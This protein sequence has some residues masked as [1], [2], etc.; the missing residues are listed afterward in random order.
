MAPGMQ[1]SDEVRIVDIQDLVDI[2]ADDINNSVAT[3]NWINM[4][5]YDRI[6]FVVEVGPTWNA[7]DQLDD[8]HVNQASTAA[9]A[10]T[11]ALVPAVNID[12]TAAT[13]PASGSA[14]KSPPP[15]AIPKAVST[16]S[17]SNAR[18]PATPAPTRCGRR[19]SV[20]VPDI[21]A[22]T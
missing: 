17:G 16:G 5:L 8:L 12:Q 11:K 10:G 18:R 3:A 9:G 14:S 6:L 1:I 21:R 4:A 20:T 15:T 13:P 19:R 7:A 2:G 22:T